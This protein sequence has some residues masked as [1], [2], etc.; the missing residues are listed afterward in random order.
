MAEE[1]PARPTESTAGAEG[2]GDAPP[3]A[4]PDAAQKAEAPA[5]PAPAVSLPAAKKAKPPE[6]KPV[7]PLRD[8]MYGLIYPA[9]LGTGLVLSG[10]R[11][12]KEPSV[13]AALTDPA[14]WAAAAAGLFFSASFASVFEDPQKT[15]EKGEWYGWGPFFIDSVEVVLMFACFYFLGL[16][17][18]PNVPAPMLY[19]AYGL[20]IAEIWWQCLWRKSVGLKPMRLW[21]MK[22]GVSIVLAIGLIYGTEDPLSNIVVSLLV[23]LFVVIYVFVDPRYRKIPRM[24]G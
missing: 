13:V 2:H 24:A 16:F 15:S 5:A 14:L 23:A 1:I 9:V 4:V 22:V 6:T 17:E 3:P 7:L 21:G 11:A 12:T 20:L 19:W 8:V 18:V 10:Q